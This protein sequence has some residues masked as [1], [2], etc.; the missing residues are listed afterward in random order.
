MSTAAKLA[1]VMSGDLE[2]VRQLGAPIEIVGDIA[3]AAICAP[4]GHRLQGRRF[5]GHRIARVGLDRWRARQARAMGEV[6]SHARPERR[7][8]CHHWSRAR[9][10]GRDDTREAARSADLA[11][12]Y[13][14]G[15][16]AYKNFA[17]EGDAASDSANRGFQTGL[18]CPPSANPAILVGRG[19]CRGGGCPTCAAADQLWPAK[20]AMRA[21]KRC[22]VSVHHT[23]VP[24]ADCPIRSRKS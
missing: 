2:T 10:P 17:P 5:L 11:F 6:R 23:A 4:P 3:R 24:A 1:A 7:S 15:A 19:P 8:L 22:R 18:A 12:G 14:G 13:Q 9:P 20:L 21:D 16:G